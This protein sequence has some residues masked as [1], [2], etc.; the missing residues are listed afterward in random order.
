MNP[1]HT[2]PDESI[3]RTLAALH[4][5]APPAGME[6]RIAQNVAQRLAEQPS[7]TPVWRLF[8]ARAMPQ[9]LWL[10]GAITGFAAAS[11]AF[12]TFLVASHLAQ[13]PSPTAANINSPGL[14]GRGFNRAVSATAADGTLL[15]E[16]ASPCTPSLTPTHGAPSILSAV[17]RDV[18]R[19]Q[20]KAPDGLAVANA[21]RPSLAY[22]SPMRLVPA[23]FAPSQPAPPAPLTAQERALLQLARNPAALAALNPAAEQRSEAEREAAYKKFFAPSPELLAAEKAEEEAVSSSTTTRQPAEVRN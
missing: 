9:S 18:R 11:L 3:D 10:R 6:T 4:A 22:S 8:A 5:A 12:A 7:P 2:Q 19:A 17:R 1:V 16:G 13:T 20:S 21:V 14:K 23:S 15:P